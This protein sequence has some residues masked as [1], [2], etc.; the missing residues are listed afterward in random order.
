MVGH[1]S[2]ARNGTDDSACM[3]KR[4][5]L[6]IGHGSSFVFENHERTVIGSKS[7]LKRG[8]TDTLR[9]VKET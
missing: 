3:L 6:L 4:E 9:Q 8:I 5:T 7:L 2:E 1:I